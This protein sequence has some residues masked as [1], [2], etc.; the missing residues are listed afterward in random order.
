MGTDTTPSVASTDSIN[1]TEAIDVMVPTAFCVHD[2]NSANW[3]IRRIVE[4]RQ[5]AARVK[6]WADR[7]RR[8]AERQEQF[9]LNHYGQQL[10]DWARQQMAQQQDRRRGVSLPAGT[11]GFRTVP[12]RLTV[13]DE[14]QLL[15]WCRT[16]LPSA[17]KTVESVLKLTVADHVRSTGECPN[18]VEFTGQNERFYIA[19]KK[20]DF[21]EGGLNDLAK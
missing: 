15:N 4:S 19:A 8:R 21:V 11:I 13:L 14:R 20:S 2:A 9:F 12:P 16:H 17:V 18:G 5:Y 6:N 10:E 1:S 3:V 7:E